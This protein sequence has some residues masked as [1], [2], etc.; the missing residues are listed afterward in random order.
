VLTRIS[1]RASSMPARETLAAFAATGATLAIHLAVHALDHVVTALLPFYGADCP[2]AVVVR[3]SW[4]DERVISGTL[5]TLPK[6][7]AGVQR[8]AL[9]LVGPALAAEGFRESALYDP[10]Y[11]RRFR[12]G[13]AA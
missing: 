1:G 8:T 5:A 7:A 6:L 3:A 10:G 2:A 11:R 12:D 13:E 9:I 4:P